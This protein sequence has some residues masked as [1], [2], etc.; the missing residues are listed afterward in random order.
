MEE[1]ADRTLEGREDQMFFRPERTARLEGWKPAEP[2][3][4][5]TVGIG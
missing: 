5:G 1:N 2:I 3:L 4:S